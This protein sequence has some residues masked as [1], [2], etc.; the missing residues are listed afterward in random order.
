M[1]TAFTAIP[2][3]DVITRTA[4]IPMLGSLAV[5]AFVLHGEEP[6]L[7]DTGTVAGSDEFMDVLETV[8]NPAA[9]RW[10]WLTHTDFDH[11][12]SLARLL[13]TNPNLRVLTSFLGVGIMG[14][15]SSP[16]PMDRV[17]LINVGQTMTTGDGRKLTAIRPPTYDNPITAGFVDD[18]TGVLFSSDCFGGLL[19][20][21][22]QN[23]ADLDIGTLQAGQ[24]RW[25]TIDSSWVHDVDTQVFGRALAATQAI[26]PTM[27]CSS[28]LPPAPGDMLR[29]FVDSLSQVPSADRFQG[30][31]QAALEMMIAGMAAVPAGV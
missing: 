15:S 5:N 25:A 12:G 7:V 1:T 28:H 29:V 30:P 26:E 11:I 27:V 19:P 3:I 4:D 31:D 17:H 14:L 20:E 13:D 2:G 9:I 23:A 18:R 6:I 21:V 8:I 22:P 16:L 10:I 24:V